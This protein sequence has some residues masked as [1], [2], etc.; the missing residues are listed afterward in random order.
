MSRSYIYI[1]PLGNI[2]L[3]FFEKLEKDLEKKF[4]FEV[5]IKNMKEIPNY[6]YNKDRDQYNGRIILNELENINFRNAEKILAITEVDLFMEDLNFIFGQA[7]S[8]GKI[9]LISTKRLNPEFYGKKLDRDLFYKRILKEA[10]H[11]LGHT[12]GLKHCENK[13]C[14]MCI[15]NNIG[16][17]DLKNNDFCEECGKL[18]NYFTF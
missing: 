2:D 4:G 18:Y 3:D 15:S 9:C 13:K 11:E 8:N 5:K 6:S 1:L 16:N 17:T 10:I 7:E 12:F 14:V